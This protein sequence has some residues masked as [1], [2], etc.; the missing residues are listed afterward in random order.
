MTVG[1]LHLSGTITF[2]T[3]E[4][5]QLAV[6]QLDAYTARGQLPAIFDRVDDEATLTITFKA[7]TVPD[8]TPP[9]EE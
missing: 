6:S 1:V 9:S 5:Y 8:M 3:L 7:D 2:P 4:V